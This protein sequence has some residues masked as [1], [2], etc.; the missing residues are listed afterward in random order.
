M[1]RRAG[2]TGKL[3]RMTDTVENTRVPVPRDKENDHS[4]EA[5]TA[6]AD[7]VREQTGVELEH[8]TSYSLDPTTLS[9]NVE[10][11]RGRR[12]GADR[13][14]RPAEGE[15]RA[16]PGRLLRAARHRRG[17]A[18]G[19]L[20]PRHAAAARGR[21]RDHHDPRRPHAARAVVPVPE[22]ARGA[23]VRRVAARALRRDQG[24]GRGHHQVRRAARHRAVLGR[25]AC[26]TRA[27][28]T[29]PATPPGRTSRARP[30]TRR[31]SGSWRTTRRSSSTSSS[32]TS[33]PTRRARR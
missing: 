4:R 28:T 1:R 2:G 7:F 26:S 6:R 32:R 23:R 11:L 5:A 13:P 31:A 12:A 22:R 18:R 16:R 19:E 33:P 9:G 21:R 24:G 3:P 8:V 20:Q 10:Q 17:H 14:R 25:A 29:A 30:P 27:S 15:R